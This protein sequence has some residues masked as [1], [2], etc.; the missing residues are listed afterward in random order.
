M[1]AELQCVMCYLRPSKPVPFLPKKKCV[2]KGLVND[3]KT[4]KWLHTNLYNRLA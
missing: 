4:G 3:V 2:W 1:L